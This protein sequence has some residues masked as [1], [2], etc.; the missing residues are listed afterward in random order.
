MPSVFLDTNV[1]KFAATALPRLRPRKRVIDWGHTKSE[2]IIH[3]FIYSNPNH[4]IKDSRHRREADLLEDVA[5]C[6]KHGAI[7]A[8]MQVEAEFESWGL[9]NMLGGGRFYGAEID[10]VEAPIKYER[11][12]LGAG[13]DP[14]RLRMSF[15]TGIDHPRFLQLQKITGAFQG[16]GRY[17]QNQLL[18]AFHVWCAEHNKCDYFLTLDYCLIRVVTAHKHHPPSTKLVCPSE[19][20]KA[21]SLD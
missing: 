13:L 6:V 14:D 1:L 2:M 18:D 12:L 21:L 7:K 9:P 8:V 10:F 20:L 17:C 4:R 5:E 19:L 16:D 3:D 15:L 11:I